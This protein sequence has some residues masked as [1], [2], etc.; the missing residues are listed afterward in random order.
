MMK[1][2]QSVDPTE[3]VEDNVLVNDE[4][5]SNDEY[6]SKL[7]TIDR[8]KCSVQLY[9][10][11]SCNIETFREKVEI[12]FNQRKDVRE[13]VIACKVENFGQDLRLESIAKIR[14]M[15]L[16]FFNNLQGIY[17]DLPGVRTVVHDCRDL[18]NCD[19]L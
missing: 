9:P 3:A 4:F 1:L 13:K 19:E 15:W 16:N 17:E 2:N 11:Y 18:S 14:N 12:Y 7:V 5:C 10:V 6:F 8:R